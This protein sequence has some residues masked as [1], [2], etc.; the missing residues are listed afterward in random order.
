[1]SSILSRV[2]QTVQEIVTDPRHGSPSGS[3]LPVESRRVTSLFLCLE[4]SPPVV[5]PV[6]SRFT[7]P[8]SEIEGPCPINTCELFTIDVFCSSRIQMLTSLFPCLLNS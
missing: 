7:G 3:L 8:S 5:G 2:V 6:H 1:M 4:V